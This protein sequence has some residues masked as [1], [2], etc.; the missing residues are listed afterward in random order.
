MRTILALSLA[1][2]LTAAAQPKTPELP[3]GYWPLAKSEEILKKTETIRLAPDLSSLTAEEKSGLKDLLEAGSF[4]QK[5]YEEQSHHQAKYGLD[6]LKASTS[7]SASRRRRRTSWSSIACTRDR[8]LR[9]SPTSV[10]LSSPS[11]SNVPTRNMYP[12]DA[13]KEEIDCFPRREPG[14]A[15]RD[16]RRAHRGPPRHEGEHRTRPEHPQRLRRIAGA[17]PGRKI[18]RIREVRDAP[19]NPKFFYAVPYPIAYA[20][21]IVP[22]FRLLTRAAQLVPR[23][24]TPSSRATSATAPATS[25]PTTTR[26]GDA[27]WVTGRFKHLNAQIGAYETYDDALYGVK[28]FH[29]LSLL[30]AERAGDG[31]SCARPWRAAGDRGRAALRARTRRVQRR[32]PGRRLRGHRRLRPGPRHQHRHASCP[33]TRS[34]RAATGARSCCARTS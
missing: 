19:G 14:D 20:D 17:A 12:L 1:V 11:T 3:A 28:A 18:E 23:P 5:L 9:R 30:L 6:R 25:S 21:C 10:R 13:T 2:T 22:A 31:A 7:S 29:S 33:T 32:H 16:P 8:S 26:A 24:A 4:M 27:S 15:R 34:S